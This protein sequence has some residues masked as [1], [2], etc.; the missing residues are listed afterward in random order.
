MCTEER[1][2]VEKLDRLPRTERQP[3]GGSDR[4]AE[5]VAQPQL[6]ADSLA[7]D[8]GE[9]DV[10]AGCGALLEVEQ[11]PSGPQAA[12]GGDRGDELAVG[13]RGGVVR[14]ARGRD[15]GRRSFAGNEPERAEDLVEPEHRTDDVV[16]GDGLAGAQLEGLGHRR[17]PQ[18][19]L[20]AK[21]GV[22]VDREGAAVEDPEIAPPQGAGLSVVPG[23][24]RHHEP[25]S[26]LGGRARKK[27]C[28]AGD[29]VD[30]GGVGED[31]TGALDDGHREVGLGVG[32]EIGSRENAVDL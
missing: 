22:D 15:D 6:D 10:A 4:P 17:Q 3:L 2:N 26:D 14:R 30:H 29:V 32:G 20:E 12:G 9:P 23:N 31:T 11:N 8:L 21:L 18:C 27:D 5:L 28:V 13:P 19:A 24:H 1:E 16:D 7:V 25:G